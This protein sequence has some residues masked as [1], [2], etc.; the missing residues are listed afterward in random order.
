ME[1][2]VLP[3]LVNGRL[4]ERRP[5][6]PPPGPG[7][8]PRRAGRTGRAGRLVLVGVLLTCLT[9]AVS[10]AVKMFATNVGDSQLQDALRAR[11]SSGAVAGSPEL[12]GL[13]A[14]APRDGSAA[15]LVALHAALVANDQAGPSGGDSSTAPSSSHSA[16]AASQGQS[17]DPQLPADG[18]GA[19]GTAEADEPNE[20]DDAPSTVTPLAE[21][22]IPAIGVDRI[23]VA[24]TSRASLAQGIGHLKGSPAPGMPGNTVLA[25]HRTTHGA[26]LR[27]IDDLKLGDKI[28]LKVP[29]Q[30]DAVYE[31]RATKVVTATD[32]DALLAT[33]GVRLTMLSCTPP[34]SASHRYIVQAE[35]VAGRNVSRAL[36]PQSWHPTF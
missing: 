29:G 2:P 19:G 32:V 7:A 9:L 23:V 26:P 4:P 22:V 8:R 31:V 1:R 16:A 18:L 13:A 15:A 6:T 11:L 21:L 35:L 28:I 27:H 5:Q 20:P 25:G 12:V 17:E 10:T 24:G 36:P 33:P 34:G 14:A 30:P 3:A